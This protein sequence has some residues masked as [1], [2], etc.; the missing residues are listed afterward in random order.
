MTE[1]NSLTEAVENVMISM[2]ENIN[3]CLP[4][5]IE[6]YNRKEQNT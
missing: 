4:G 1:K 2:L 5:R 6:S 3:T